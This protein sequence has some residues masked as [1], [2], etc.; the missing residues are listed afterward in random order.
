MVQIC[1]YFLEKRFSNF[2]CTHITALNER[3]IVENKDDG[4]HYD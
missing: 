2:A 3:E 4:S 1:G